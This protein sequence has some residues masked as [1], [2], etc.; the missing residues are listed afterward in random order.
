[1]LFLC[2]VLFIFP[3]IAFTQT[4]AIRI[5]ELMAQNAAIIMD[6][7][8]EYSDWI[9]IYNPTSN[10]VDLSGWWLT[11]DH[12]EP[13]KW[14]FPQVTLPAQGYL[15]VFASGKN[16]RIAGQELHTN[17]KLSKSGEFLGLYNSGLTAVSIFNPIF[18]EQQENVSY[19]FDGVQYLN[20]LTPTPGTENQFT[21]QLAVYPPFFSAK[22]G[23]YESSFKV[24]I[25]APHSG[26]SIYYTTN[27]SEPAL[28]NGTLYS[29]SVIITT[30]T[31]LRAIVVMSATS[32]SSVTSQT[33]LFL[34][35]VVK[36]PNNPVG[37]PS[38]WG[39]YTAMTGDAIADYE[40]DQ[41][42]VQDSRY[43]NDFKA[44]MLSI[45]TISI[46]TDINHLFSKSVHPDTG[47]IYI[48]TGAPG[49]G[50]V[51]ELGEGW[52][53]PAAV[54]YFNADGSLDFS[55]N[56]GIRLHG[57]HSRRPEKCPKHSFRL[58]FRSQYGASKLNYPIFGQTNGVIQQFNTIILRAGYGNSWLHMSPGERSK[59]QFIRDLWAK[60]FQL[61]SG[62]PGGHGNYAH[63]Y[64]NGLYWGIYNPTER[65]DKNFGFAY[66]GGNEEDYDVIKDY[67]EVVDG[68]DLAWNE[69]MTIARQGLASDDN[70]YRIQGKTPDGF[71]NPAFPAYVDV[72]NLIDYM[73]LNFYGGNW[74]WDHHNWSALRNRVNPGN[75]FI[76]LSW[77]AEHI[78]ETVSA[79]VLSEN[80]SNCP[81]ELFQRL[82]KNN[83]F[84]YLFAQ[85]VEYMCFNN[86]PLT[87]AKSLQ[88]WMNRSNQVEPA[89]IAES[90]RWGDYR[91]DVHR[92]SSA[93]YELYTKEH[94]L[95]QQQYIVEQHFPN[96][97][98]AFINELN[99]ANLYPYVA[100]D[101]PELDIFN[102][103]GISR[104]DQNYPNPVIC[105]TSITYYIAQSNFVTLTLYD[106]L[107]KEILVLVNEYQDKDSYT[108][109]Y[110]ASKLP[111]GVYYYKLTVGDNKIKTRKMLVAREVD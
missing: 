35:D 101:V 71:S 96:R 95:A 6:A 22:H 65:L 91:R 43:K 9:E 105:N 99:S 62:N 21:S 57:G 46:V 10:P 4:P 44:A 80:N 12:A 17:F 8:G 16:Y 66:L 73:I 13:M 75:G 93:P 79:N 34:N 83:K 33:Y 77:D 41:E 60:D 18:P 72:A 92:I 97:T 110:D 59:G 69:M 26:G 64:I 11:D 48:Y 94:W 30:T 32:K 47:G 88:R 51:S 86:G 87:P 85:R 42:V 61:E 52:E 74:D 56:C 55:I 20:C 109:Q 100:T 1:M 29:D 23:F 102:N 76:F 37:Y 39:P 98:N 81:S 104:L 103:T 90:A 53:R 31:V 111:S 19:A 2:I 25:S 70:Y 49:D 14:E 45:P 67:A 89:V 106:V 58:A 50:E 108:I 78:I 38:T 27:G 28:N 68:N 63:L 15:L 107:G 36:Q 82:L 5:N 7:D 84:R 24:G 3:V 40:M 54:E